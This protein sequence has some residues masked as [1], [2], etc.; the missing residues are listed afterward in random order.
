MWNMYSLDCFPSKGDDQSRL[1]HDFKKH[2]A[3]PSVHYCWC[4]HMGVPSIVVVQVYRL[5]GTRIARIVACGRVL[6]LEILDVGVH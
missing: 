2:L 4:M 3:C 1:H 5:V 6:Y